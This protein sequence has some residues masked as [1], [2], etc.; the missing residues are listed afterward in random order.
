MNG[1]IDLRSDT[2]TRPV[3][4]MRTAMAV[5][6]VGD[7]VF[8]DDPTVN[9][10]QT[11]FAE[12]AGKEEALFVTSGTQA[13]QTAL[14]CHTRPGDEIICDANSHIVRY[15]GGAPAALSGVSTAALAGERGI[16]TADM[17]AAAIRPDDVHE[18]VSSVVVVENTH[19]KG[20]GTVWPIGQL[21]DVC[22]C[23]HDRGLKTHLDGARIFNAVAATGIGLVEWAVHFDSI[24]VCFSKGLGAPV[25]SI[26]AGSSEFIR[27]A[28]RVRKMLGGGMRQAGSL[29][30][31][32]EYALDH[33][34]QRLVEDHDNARLLAA[35]LQQL[36]AFDVEPVST[37]MVFWSMKGMPEKVAAFA[38][39]CR[40][41]GV[42]FLHF[43]GVRFRAVTH[44]DITR[45]QVLTAA[46]IIAKQVR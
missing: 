7:D 40:E 18:P 29:A 37:N 21:A 35:E 44:L 19:N 25:G 26:L 17:V 5:A 9:R 2:V 15:E 34:V 42:W 6:E 22:R 12:M 33:H 16:F 30:A 36:G 39:A 4:A 43:G 10:L 11:R 24:A 1:I 41:R 20:G 8:G 3:P 46:R 32:A 23:A 31:A 14:K 13:N 27:C 38:E 28:R 45:E